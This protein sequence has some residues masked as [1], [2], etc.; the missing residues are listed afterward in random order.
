MEEIEARRALEETSMLKVQQL[1][2][3]K[4]GAQRE[5]ERLSG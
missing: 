4:R 3:E 5:G 1:R 2:L